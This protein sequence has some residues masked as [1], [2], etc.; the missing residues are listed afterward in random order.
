MIHGLNTQKIQDLSR[1]LNSPDIAV[2]FLSDF[3]AMLPERLER[4][5]AAVAACDD[6]TAMDAVLSLTITAAMTGAVDTGACCHALQSS[7]R[8][9]D[10]TLAHS[11]VATL[12]D[13]VTTLQD[14]AP[15]LL[16]QASNTLALDEDVGCTAA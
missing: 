9:V 11:Q 12:A 10:F 2:R 7:I 13:I 3:L 16:A 14:A 1:D 15:A 5:Q 4:I 6:E 8:N